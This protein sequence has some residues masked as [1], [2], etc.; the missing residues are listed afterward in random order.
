M[1]DRYRVGCFPDVRNP[2]RRVG[3]DQAP[4][5]R[6]SHRGLDMLGVCAS[7]RQG[8]QMKELPGG[9]AVNS[10]D[11][12]CIYTDMHGA[13]GVPG[14]REEYFFRSGQCPSMRFYSHATLESGT[15]TM[16]C[17]IQKPPV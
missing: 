9:C 4:L 3:K 14:M 2:V 1:G 8:W 13:G 16:G 17:T 11:V 12:K 5:L 10:S 6:C 15:C 7:R